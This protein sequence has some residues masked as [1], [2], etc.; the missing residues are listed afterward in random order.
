LTCVANWPIWRQGKR[1]YALQT[2]ASVRREVEVQKAQ[3]HLPADGR[4]ILAIHEK[5]VV[6][7]L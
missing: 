1:N 7:E 6:A 5:H 3:L 4:S 2:A